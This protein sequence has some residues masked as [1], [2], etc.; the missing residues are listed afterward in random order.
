MGSQRDNP[1]AER[2]LIDRV[3]CEVLLR[4][5]KWSVLDQHIS[6]YRFLSDTDHFLVLEALYMEIK[7]VDGKYIDGGRSSN[8]VIYTLYIYNIESGNL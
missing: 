4:L 5:V 3:L 2:T 7:V 1:L 6:A 8:D